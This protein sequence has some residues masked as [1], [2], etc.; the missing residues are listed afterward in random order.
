MFLPSELDYS[1]HDGEVGWPESR[2]PLGMLFLWEMMLC[3]QIWVVFLRQCL[4]NLLVLNALPLCEWFRLH[5]GY[6]ESKLP[7]SLKVAI[8]TKTSSCSSDFWVKQG[9]FVESWLSYCSHTGFFFLVILAFLTQPIE[10]YSNS[11]SSVLSQVVKYTIISAR[12]L[13]AHEFAC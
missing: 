5:G 11:F 1:T 10:R 13:E 12:S 6:S 4:W 8:I 7:Y 9:L 2:L 3:F